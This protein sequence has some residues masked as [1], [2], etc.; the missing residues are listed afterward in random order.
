VKQSGQ[1]ISRR[2]YLNSWE[3]I[4]SATHTK[5][6]AYNAITFFLE[7][8]TMCNKKKLFKLLW[9]LDSEHFRQ[10]GR[11]VTGYEYAAWPMGPVPV[12]L[13]NAIENQESDLT[14]S[15]D[16]NRQTD[17]RNRTTITLVNKREFDKRYFSRNELDLL[18]RL[19]YNFDVMTGDE[20][21]AFTHREGTPWYK[22]WVTEG[23]QQA[24][25]PYEYALDN[26]PED[27]KESIL[28][29]AEERRA[30]LTNYK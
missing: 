21:E 23:R 15:F 13:H 8:T 24:E 22:V 4:M 25:I 26:L 29:I 1:P 9:L 14:E 18:Q 17:K 16:I 2:L 28:A 20:M 27:E 11:S 30:F 7:N 6:K 10:I 3:N 12:E 5:E 19:A